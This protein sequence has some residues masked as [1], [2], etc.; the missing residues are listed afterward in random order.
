MSNLCYKECQ[1]LNFG[2]ACLNT[3]LRKNNIFSS[4][5]VRLA[6]L[7]KNGIQHVKDLAIKNL[8]D[9]LTILKWN[10]ENNIFFFRIS[11]ELFPFATYKKK[12]NNITPECDNGLYSLDFADSYLKEIGDYAKSNNIRLTMHPA[13]FCVLSSKS[14]DVVGNS[15]NELIHHYKKYGKKEKRFFSDKQVKEFVEEPDFD[16]EIYQKY[17][18]IVLENNICTFH[19]LIKIE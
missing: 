6:T 4:R 9:L 7:E 2:Y 8:K 11:S 19:T 3:E 17:N 5:T 10:K 13:Q 18:N 16:I 14:E 12:I 15:F 1:H